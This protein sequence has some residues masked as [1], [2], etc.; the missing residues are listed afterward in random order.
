MYQDKYFN[1]VMGELE[2]FIGEDSDKW[3]AMMLS[4][5]LSL[6]TDVQFELQDIDF[7]IKLNEDEVKTE[8]TRKHCVI[9]GKLTSGSVGKAGIKWK[10][11]CQDC[12][13]NKDDEL[14]IMLK[15][16]KSFL[17]AVEKIIERWK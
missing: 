13:D 8:D 6:L 14:D 2:A 16:T 11:I 12:K 15:G 3:D 9:C 5:A 1:R 10:I 17:D 4:K 7:R